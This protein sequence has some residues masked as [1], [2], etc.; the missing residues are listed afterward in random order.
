[1]LVREVGNTLLKVHLLGNHVHGKEKDVPSCRCIISYYELIL[2]LLSMVSNSESSTLISGVKDCNGRSCTLYLFPE[3]FPNG[4]IAM[5]GL[6]EEFVLKEGPVFA[7]NV[8]SAFAFATNDSAMN[9]S[10]LNR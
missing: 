7:L 6:L 8:A 10:S 4:S 2:E 3:V 5:L 1:M 9:C